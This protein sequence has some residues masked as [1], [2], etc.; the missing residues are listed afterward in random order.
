MLQLAW[1]LN[2]VV[3]RLAVAR[4]LIQAPG[5]EQA[6]S[7]FRQGDDGVVAVESDGLHQS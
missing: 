6:A 3:E 1:L 4:V 2:A 7:L 5:F